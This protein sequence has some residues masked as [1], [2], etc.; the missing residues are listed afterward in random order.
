[1]PK[2]RPLLLLTLLLAPA[3]PGLA[4]PA[5]EARESRF[6]TSDGVELRVLEAG[7]ERPRGTLVLIPGWGMGAGIWSRQFQELAGRWRLLSYDPRSQGASQKVAFG[8]DPGRRA[9]DLQELLQAR[10]ASDAV[11][12]GWSL[13]A[14]ELMRALSQGAPARGAVFVDNSLDRA[15]AQPRPRDFPLLRRLREQPYEDVVP[16]FIDSLFRSPLPA[17]ERRALVATALAT[18]R[19]Q[20]LASLSQASRGPGLSRLLRA[21]PQLK[22]LLAVSSTLAPEALALRAAFPAQVRA[23]IFSGA[24]HALFV[25]QAGSFNARLESFAAGLP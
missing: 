2:T 4:E 11:L 17:A 21:R 13:G 1:M 5:P 24:G 9:R 25:D 8:Q 22:V 20:A 14:L 12:V 10:R 15:Y 18:P 3:L 16:E 6:T 7:P 23:E 19:E